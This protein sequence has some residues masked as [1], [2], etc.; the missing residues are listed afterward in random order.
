MVLDP[1]V[2]DRDLRR[3]IYQRIPPAELRDAVNSPDRIVRPLDDH[4]FDFLESRYTYLRQFTPEF[5]D[6]FA[7]RSGGD[8]ALLRAVELLRQLNTKRPGRGDVPRRMMSPPAG[9]PS[10]HP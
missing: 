4:Y 5:I 9:R 10:L 3:A 7:F 2:K 1:G 6:A 8:S